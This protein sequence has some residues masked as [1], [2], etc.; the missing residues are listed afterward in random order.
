MNSDWTE[1]RHRHGGHP[2]ADAQRLNVDPGDVTDFSVNVAPTG[3][4]N[5]LL[6]RWSELKRHLHQYPDRHGSG[7]RRFVSQQLDVPEANVLGGNGV[8]ELLYLVLRCLNPE[9]VTLLSPSF[10]DYRRAAKASGA[11]VDDV[12]LAPPR[13]TARPEL[14]DL[15]NGSP[16]S[17]VLIA[18]QPNN[19]TGTVHPPETLLNLVES[20]PDRWVLV[21]EAFVRFTT[22]PSGLSMADLVPDYDNLIVFR[23]LTKF[24]AIPGLR[25]GAVIAPSSVLNR[26]SEQRAPWMVNAIADRAARILTDTTPYD[27]SLKNLIQSER[28]RLRTAYASVKGVRVQPSEAN[29]FLARWTRTD[30]LDDLLKHLLEHGLYVR[31]ARN[32]HGL[33][34]NWFRFAIR[35]ERENNQ[36]LDAIRSAPS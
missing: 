6:N 29:F 7:L 3:P 18:G 1:P 2:R 24:Y 19:P 28:D 21:D 10:H 8:A 11:S 32:F 27:R 22:D 9:R 31:D 23:S 5:A 17:D 30:S 4:P 34:G 12:H 15:R 33:D 16:G 36:L 35:T 13:E 20:R 14:P 25:A 26:M